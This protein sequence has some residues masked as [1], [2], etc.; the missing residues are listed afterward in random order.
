M[1][2]IIRIANAMAAVL[3]FAAAL[4]SCDKVD[5]P[6]RHVVTDG[7]PTVYSVRYADRDINITGAYMDE[8]VCLLGDNL[9][10]VTELWFNDQQAVLNT[11]FITAN[12]LIVSVPSNMPTETTNK[13]YLMN[14]ERRDTVTFDFQVLPPVPRVSSMTNEWAN[15]G[16]RVS[17]YGSFFFPDEENPVEISFP[18]ATVAQSDITFNGSTEM[19]FIVPEGAN[20][21]YVTVTTLSGSSR[22]KFVY[23]DS[24]NILFD[25]DGSRGGRSSGYG[26]R[27]GK[28]HNPGDDADWMNRPLDGSYLYF[29]GAEL[30]DTGYTW[31]EDDFS[32]NYWPGAVGSANP[33][34]YSFPEFAEYIEEYGA[35]NLQMKFEICVSAANPWQSC[36]LQLIF[37]SEEQVSES[38]NNNAFIS[39]TDV[40]RGLYNPWEATGSFD[41]AGDWVTVAVPITDFKY[42][43]DG[44][45]CSTSFTADYFHGLTFFV[46]SGG[47]SGT[48]CTPEIAID[49]I[50]VVPV[51]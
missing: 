16:E 32:F 26:W 10:S 38:N 37:T 17:I 9:T 20:P 3:V 7:V 25:W 14:K 33:P 21:G 24:R 12:T 39:A 19:S 48:T 23:K 46:Y 11:S 34:L 47:V 15:P 41:T 8:V 50:R 44:S 35:A 31:A 49:N 6:N 4:V 27:A 2:T 51:E 42:A 18:G 1:K 40:P 30:E 29:G 43:P 28:I 22:S 5:Y 13:I 45:A 36:A